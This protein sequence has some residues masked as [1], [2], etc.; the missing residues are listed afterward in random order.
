[1][2]LAK[3]KLAHFPAVPAHFHRPVD[4]G[5]GCI[6]GSISNLLEMMES[7]AYLLAWNQMFAAGGFFYSIA[8]S[9]TRCKSSSVPLQ[10]GL[11]LKFSVPFR[12]MD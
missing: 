10:V 3:R 1:M 11:I 8:I 9:I 12:K 4:L 5:C 2:Q 7:G 6:H